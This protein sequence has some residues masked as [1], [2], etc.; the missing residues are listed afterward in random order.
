MHLDTASTTPP[1]PWHSLSAEDA[2]RI[3]GVDPGRGL[4][5]AEAEE[6]LLRHGRNTLPTRPQK[7]ALLRFLLQFHQPLVYILIAS[8]AVTALLGEFVDSGV[9]LGVVLA[10]AVISYIQEAKAVRALTA[11]A[12]TMTTEASALRGGRN[13]RLDAA[14]LAP[15][16]VVLLRSGDKVPA[17]VR[18][19]SARELRVD[20]S[21]LTGESLPAAKDAAPVAGD[22]VLA[23]R[24][25]M[26]YAGTLVVYGQAR[27]VV[28]ATGRGTE[29]GRIST[30]M[31]AAGDL[32]TPLT[33]K[34]SRFSHLLLLGILALAAV[35]F[36]LGLWRGEAA[37]DMFMASVALAVGAIPE[38][39]PA[40]VTIIL[41]IGVSRMAARRAVIR[42]LPAV[43]TL[44]SVTVICT[45]KT[46]TLTENQMTVRRL[47]AGGQGAAVTGGGYAPEGELRPDGGG[48]A[49]EAM[50]QC[51]LAGL[52][53][54]DAVLRAPDADGQ[55]WRVEGDPSEAA[56]LVS[57]AKAGL[58]R[59]TAQAEAPRL[60]ELPFES[61]HQYM[62]TLNR[63]GGGA[64][65]WLK[66]SAERVLDRCGSA[67]APDGVPVPLDA[68]TAHREA[69]DMAAQGLRVLA[70]ARGERPAGREG[71]G[72][73]EHADVAGGL[74][75]LGLQ[76]MIDPPRAEAVAAVARCRRAGIMVKMIT[77]DHAGTAVAVGRML[78]LSGPSC[79][80]G[81]GCE[82]LTGA[83]LERIPDA[84]LTA[85]A[86]EVS[87][88]ARVSPE[89]KLRL[90]RALQAG[91][92]VAAMT[93]DGVN[94]APALKQADIG[95]AMGRAGTDAAKEAADMVLTD[96][97]FASIAAAVEEGR[98]VFDNLVKFIAWTLPTNIG[99]GMTIL[100][101]SLFGV[102]LPI[103]P[104]QILWINMTT[105]ACLGLM[106]SFEPPEAGLMDRPPRDPARPIL[107]R[108]LSRRIVSVGLLLLV[109]AF[110]LFEWELLS[111]AG[112]A[113]A[114][115][116]AVN[117]FVLVETAYLFNSRSATRSPLALGF[118]SNPWVNVGAGLMLLLQLAY[119][120]APPMNA[121][122]SS[123]PIGPAQWARILGAALLVFF[124]VEAEKK[125]L[126]AQKAHRSP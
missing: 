18:L 122:F 89:Q 4:S 9:I 57:A 12:E 103:L 28:A 37:A 69:E 112:V 54:N 2:A 26:A 88:F 39:L 73:L 11:L 7:S 1:A 108:T 43:E 124:A 35:N 117:V 44:G 8:G 79:T 100:T 64:A 45:D 36:G 19:L 115:T 33:R 34:I 10:N 61:E 16:D 102:T 72:D 32:E 14:L 59:E 68:A 90:V 107:D 67:L 92:E 3:L 71:Q 98:G 6:R 87:V 50:R 20:E 101:A 17:D 104:V 53:C 114:R 97:N 63:Q 84:G 30:L 22:A 29:L 49:T 76:G 5:P 96:D 74:V 25:G 85:R 81:G 51:L 95:V 65:I 31:E 80:P 86:R 99:E 94:D 78:G 41:A 120:Y 109:C 24:R 105:A 58:D 52:L 46:G 40:A 13:V 62:A 82:A 47:W 118:F 70:F 121:L 116:V 55:P 91:G 66:G 106:L 60:N 75:F 113:Q 27:A 123:A 21:M 126:P 111:G 83:E 38:G 56:L 23:D 77:G 125:L 93:G 42:R 15:G 48:P 119:T 110:G